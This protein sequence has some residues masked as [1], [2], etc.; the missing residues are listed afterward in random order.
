MNLD[1]DWLNYLNG[2]ES[3]DELQLTR[4]DEVVKIASIPSPMP[5]ELYISTKTEIAFLNKPMLLREMFWQI[6]VQNYDTLEEGI[7]KKQMKFISNTQEEYDD[8]QN[9][10]KNYEEYYIEQHI[11]STMKADIGIKKYKD[12]R[13]ISIGISKKDILSNRSKKKGAFYNCF[14]L[15]IRIKCKG[16]FKEFHTKIFNTGKIE[17]PGIQTH[18]MFIDVK[19]LL[20]KILQTNIDSSLNYREDILKNFVG[21]E[22]ILINSNFDCN[23]YLDRYKLSQILKFERNLNVIYD[24]CTYPGVRCKFYYNSITNNYTGIKTAENNKSI[25]FMIFRTGSVLIV[26]KCSECVL[27]HVY[28][29]ITDV[30]V[31]A[32]ITK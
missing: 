14:V 27:R 16:V 11:L 31:Y 9:N 26:G 25:S 13:K 24:S 17:L 29:Y 23:Y 22:S 2:N 1:N 4:E 8:I 20:I 12:V 30:C 21:D 6:P 18:E 15:I 10:L 3:E 19:K 32:C 5:T 28:V 7:I